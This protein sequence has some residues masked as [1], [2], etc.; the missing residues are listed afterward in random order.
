MSALPNPLGNTMHRYVCG[1]QSEVDDLDAVTDIL[2]TLP[3]SKKAE[4]A[5]G[6]LNGKIG[7]AS[8]TSI[9]FFQHKTAGRISAARGRNGERPAAIRSAFT[10]STIPEYLG[11]N[12]SANVVLPEP[13]GPAMTMHLG[14][15]SRAFFGKA[16]T[17]TDAINLVLGH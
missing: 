14:A 4:T 1:R 7:A 13:F 15:V 9:D 8:G 16:V 10:N 2:P 11:R 5:Q 6:T 17:R 3:S 12:S